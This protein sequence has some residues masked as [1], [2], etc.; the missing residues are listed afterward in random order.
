MDSKVTKLALGVAGG[1]LLAGVVA[2]AAK[3]IM[4]KFATTTTNP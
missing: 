3:Y 1:V 2:Y 4:A